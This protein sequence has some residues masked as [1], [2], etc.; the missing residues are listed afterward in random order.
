MEAALQFLR[1]SGASA[2]R[3]CALYVAM[4]AAYGAESDEADNEVRDDGTACH[5]LAQE[6]FEGRFHAEG[7]AAPNGRILTAEMF[8]A[9]DLYIDAI[10]SRAGVEHYV[11]QS[12]DCSY[13]YPGMSGTPDCWDYAPGHLRILDLK[14]GFGFVE[15]VRNSQL[16]IYAVCIAWKLGLPL[17][18]KVE[19]VICQPRAWTSEGPVRRWITTLG[20]LVE[21][22]LQLQGAATAAMA[23]GAL[24]T[25]GEWCIDCAGRSGCESFMKQCG[26]LIDFGHSAQRIDLTAEEA[27]MELIFVKK[28]IAMLEAREAALNVQVESFLR[29]GKRLPMW[30][31]KASVGREGWKPGGGEQLMSLARSYLNAEIGRP[32]TPKQAR[33]LIPSHIVDAFAEAPRSAMV[34]A[35]I[36]RY[37]AEKKFNNQG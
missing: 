19:L 32:P 34:L 27:A 20:A 7:S 2:W 17:D 1:P 15:V 6:I 22:I 35:Q 24:A 5:W 25:V 26:Q 36:G 28:A 33:K 18:T 3:H 9:V 30:Q 13:I 11:E 16:T 14:F 21:D 31:M 8:E 4:Q 29:S 37:D 23:P 12:V 10:K